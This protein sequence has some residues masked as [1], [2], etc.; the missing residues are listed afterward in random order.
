MNDWQRCKH[1]IEAALEYADGTHTIDDIEYGIATGRYHFWSGSRCAVVTE[2]VVFPKLK[3]LNFFLL[4]GDLDELKEIEPSIVE[5]A[6][7]VHGCSRA[8]GVGRK[9]FE[10]VLVGN[11][12]KPKWY[13]LAKE[14]TH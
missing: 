11:G 13:C 8:I 7:K 9:G 5:W 10:R 6:R 1:W 14:L 3:A 12:Y 4:G 2:I